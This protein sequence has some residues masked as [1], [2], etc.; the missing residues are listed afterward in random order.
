MDVRVVVP[1]G[2]GLLE[3]RRNALREIAMD[4]TAVLE[5]YGVN[6]PLVSLSQL[7][8]TRARLVELAGFTSAEEFYHR[9]TPDQEKQ[10]QEQAAQQPPPVDPA[11]MALAQAEMLKAQTA[12]KQAETNA[13]L[14]DREL[15][16]REQEIVLADDR[17]RDKQ[18]ADIAVRLIDIETRNQTTIDRAAFQQQ[19]ALIRSSLDAVTRLKVAELQRTKPDAE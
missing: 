12:A 2:A 9:I 15:A 14:K 7:A 17:E 18:A 16:I 3:D 13:A 1:L 8:N 11:Q 19:T 4:Q 6:N 10:L 5:K